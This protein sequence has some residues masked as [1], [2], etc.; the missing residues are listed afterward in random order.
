M[1]GCTNFISVR[2]SVHV[3]MQRIRS[4]AC[5]IQ[6]AQALPIISIRNNAFTFQQNITR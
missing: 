4:S 5:L 3:F 2:V 1:N 6:L